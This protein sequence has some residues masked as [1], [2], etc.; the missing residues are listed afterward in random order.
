MRVCA[1]LVWKTSGIAV[2][3]HFGFSL[4]VGGP[5]NNS[6]EELA[7]ESSASLYHRVESFSMKKSFRQMCQDC[8]FLHS[9]GSHLEGNHR[10][11]GWYEDLCKNAQSL[12]SLYGI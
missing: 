1:C 9:G 7:L 6:I 12:S 5:H 2:D 10:V 3:C 8:C 4:M 11:W